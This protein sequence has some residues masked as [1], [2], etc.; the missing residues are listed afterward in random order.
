M[1]QIVHIQ[2]AQP[3]IWICERLHSRDDGSITDVDFAV[4]TGAGRNLPKLA[5]P[6]WAEAI[7]EKSGEKGEGLRAPYPDC[8]EA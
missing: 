6:R 3:K 2:E 4:L 1:P 8:E 5:I 7:N